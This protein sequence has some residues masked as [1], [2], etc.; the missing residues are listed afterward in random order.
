V[1]RVGKGG[2]KGGTRDEKWAEG[3]EWKWREGRVGLKC[4]KGK[5][6]ANGE[7]ERIREGLS[8]GKWG[9][10]WVKRGENG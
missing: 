2:V 7:R 8:G 3:I 9:E 4:E 1:L 6:R 5:G 10:G